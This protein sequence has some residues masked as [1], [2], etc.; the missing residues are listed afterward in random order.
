MS[1]HAF[2]PLIPAA[3][4]AL[5]AAVAAANAPSVEGPVAVVYFSRADNAVAPDEADGVTSASL[6]PGT[7]RTGTTALVA[8][9]IARVTG[10]DVFPIRAANA[11]PASFDAVYARSRSEFESGTAI[12]PLPDL[13]KYRTLFVGYPTW[14]MRLPGPVATFLASPGARPANL[15]VFATH[16]GWGAGSGVQAIEA[17]FPGAAAGEPL[18]LSSKF[19]TSQ[20]AAATE[21]VRDWLAKKTPANNAS[22]S[23]AD[24]VELT[25]EAGGRT[26]TVRLNGTPEAEQ[27]L[28]MLPV[29]VRMGEYG[30][31]EYYGGIRERIRTSS[32]GQLS[33]EDGTLTYCP[34]NNT[35]AIFYAQ[36]SRPNLTMEV[37]PMGKVTSDLGVFR[38]LDSSESFRFSRR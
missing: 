30:G 29:T 32:P 28:R 31:R 4:A 12:E 6:V 16:D 37:F 1:V 8:R 17:A 18:A 25:V 9:E 27:F 22:V 35:V 14:S 5:P 3:I 20:P 7:D 26:I 23:P 13:S 34:T 15:H 2:L 36:S 33:F 21:A 24:G 11:Y 19:V 10:A 38:E